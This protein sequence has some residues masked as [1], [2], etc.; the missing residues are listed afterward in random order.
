MAALSGA[1]CDLPLEDACLDI[2]YRIAV[3]AKQE[4]DASFG[5]GMPMDMLMT[6]V[7]AWLQQ[8]TKGEPASVHAL[9]L[10]GLAP[11]TASDGRA[12]LPSF[13]NGSC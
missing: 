12:C 13:Q 2:L 9:P 4:N 3:L 11:E 7:D 1:S 8:G 6:I 5:A 10:F